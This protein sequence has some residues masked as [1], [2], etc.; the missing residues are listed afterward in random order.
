[1]SEPTNSA[2]RVLSRKQLLTDLG[3][4]EGTLLVLEKR[5]EAPPRIKLSEARF[6]YWTSDVANWIQSRRVEAVS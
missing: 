1:M 5:G 2:C 4:S 6:G 3:I